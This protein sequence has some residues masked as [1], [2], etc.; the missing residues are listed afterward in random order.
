MLPEGALLAYS[1]EDSALRLAGRG[2][3]ASDEYRRNR[4]AT[5]DAISQVS[6]LHEH[7]A[8]VDTRGRRFTRSAAPKRPSLLTAEFSLVSDGVRAACRMSKP[9]DQSSLLV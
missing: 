6:A 2:H 7:L 4:E 3:W 8:S 1:D 5:R 9:D